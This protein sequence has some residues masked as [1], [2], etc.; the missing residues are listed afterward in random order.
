VK[1]YLPTCDSPEISDS[2][3]KEEAELVTDSHFVRFHVLVAVNISI[4]VFSFDWLTNSLYEAE[5]YS[6]GH[7]LVMQLLKNFSEFYDTRR[8][9]TA[10]TSV[11]HLFLSWARPI[12]SIPLPPILS[13]QDPS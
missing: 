12:Q 10:F 3:T 8:F 6:R 11:L 1:S 7:Q 5:H 2:A 13:L 9:I 4:M